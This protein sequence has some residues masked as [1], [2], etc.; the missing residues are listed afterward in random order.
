MSNLPD[1]QAYRLIQYRPP[2]PAPKKAS[3]RTALLQSLPL[4]QPTPEPPAAMQACN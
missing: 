1:R 4:E 2:S 3:T